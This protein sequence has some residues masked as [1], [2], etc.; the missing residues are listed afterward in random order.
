M[1]GYKWC[2][3]SGPWDYRTEA[4]A[5]HPSSLHGKSRR[6]ARWNPCCRKKTLYDLTGS[7]SVRP[8]SARATSDATETI[9][10]EGGRL[11]GEIPMRRSSRFVRTDVTGTVCSIPYTR[12]IPNLCFAD[13]RRGTRGVTRRRGGLQGRQRAG[14]DDRDLGARDGRCRL[15]D[16]RAVRL[17]TEDREAVPCRRKYCQYS[18]KW[19]RAAEGN[20]SCVR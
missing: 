7:G 16:F 18:G 20:E 6:V 19:R 1:F 2:G 14:P 10:T 11:R 3:A 12:F 4:R 5:F 17:L 9:A 15:Y 13:E 8:R